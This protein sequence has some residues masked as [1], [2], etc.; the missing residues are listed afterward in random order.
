MLLGHRRRGSFSVNADVP[1]V[2]SLSPQDVS[3]SS[4]DRFASS[5]SYSISRSSPKSAMFT[6]AWFD[7][8]TI[9]VALIPLDNI[10]SQQ[11]P[12]YRRINELQREQ[13]GHFQP[14]GGVLPPEIFG[15]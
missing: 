13:K 10:S 12:G 1:G 4:E 15:G 2:P 6:N 8:A 11:S 9:I 3:S 7:F 14:K 5:T